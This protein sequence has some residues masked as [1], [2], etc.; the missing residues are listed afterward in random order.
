M[1]KTTAFLL[2]VAMLLSL[3]A[4]AEKNEA[5][6]TEPPTKAPIMEL[7]TDT[8][9]ILLSD[10]GVVCDSDAVYT[11]NDIIY[12]EEGHD[13]SYGEGEAADAHSPEEAAAHTVVHITAPGA[14]RLSGT[15]SAGQIFVDLGEDAKNDPNACVALILDN[16]DIT[17]TVAPAVFFYRVYECADDE[18]FVLQPDLSN[19][20]AAV[21]LADESTNTIRGAYVARIYKPGTTDKLHKYDAAFYSRQSM[22]IEGE[23]GFLRIEA[24]NEGLDTELHLTINGGS[25]A[26]SSQDDGINTNE[27]GISVTTING[28]ALWIQGGLGEEGDGID[29]NGALVI[30]GGNLYAM[31]NEKTGDGGIDADLGIYLNG[32]TVVASGSRN[33][34]PANLGKQQFMELSFASDV[35]ENSTVILLSEDEEIMGFLAQ[36]AFS[37]LILSSPSLQTGIRYQLKINDTVQRYSGR[38]TGPRNFGGIEPPGGVMPGTKP[39]TEDIPTPPT[40]PMEPSGIEP[41]EG[42]DR[43]PP[44][45]EN[46]QPPTPPDGQMPSMPETDGQGGTDFIIDEENHGFSGICDAN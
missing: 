44:Q 8:I 30:N 9:D 17:C 32:G 21:Y 26:I 45:G 41:P 20:G 31:A 34:S 6:S 36:R 1:K 14:Y 27:D 29:S 33:D 22:R 16:V 40:I 7:P 19:A 37:S 13:E 15:L 18:A 11:A 23:T 46:G 4:C 35:E 12:Y 10:D 38:N 42:G 3:C 39:P 28:G 24:A 43:Q 5:S 25:I 2:A